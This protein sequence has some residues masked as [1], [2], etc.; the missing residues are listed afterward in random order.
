ML[1]PP[2]TKIGAASK[3]NERL[4]VAVVMVGSAL[5]LAALI[6]SASALGTSI[7]GVP[8]SY[9]NGVDSRFGAQVIRDFLA[10]QEAEATAL[11]TGDQTPLGGRFTDSAL[12]DLVQQISSQSSRPPMVRFQPSSLTVLRALDPAD[13][14][15]T[16]EVQEDGSKAVVTSAGPNAAPTEQAISFHGD[17]WLRSPSGARYAIAD[18]H[19]QTLPSSPLPTAAVIAAALAVVMGATWLAVRRRGVRATVERGTAVQSVAVPAAPAPI[20]MPQDGEVLPETLG[21]PPEMVVRT[22]GGLHVL[23]AG[24]DWAP[25]LMSRP[26]TGFVWL[27]LLLAAIAT[28]STQVG[29]DEVARQATPGL[30]RGVQ[31]KRLRN[32]VGKGL[33]EMPPVLSDRIL[34]DPEV[35]SF[36]LDGCGV[37]AIELLELGAE[38]APGALL[39]GAQ[40]A[41]VQRV[42]QA[43]QGTFLPEFEAI[44]DLATDRR[45]TCTGL[46]NELRE[47]LVNKRVDLSLLLADAHLQAGR[48]MLAIAV[49]E[50]A[51]HDRRQRKD[52]AARLAAA[53]RGAGRDA[54][55]KALDA[56]YGS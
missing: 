20:A 8:T 7:L 26:V 9:G 13:P 51:L 40:V 4:R 23:Q 45:P 10:D 48:P 47:L 52:L 11:S 49:L 28:P 5:L 43:C 34:V 42:V 14:T 31:L 46:V 6:V 16:I 41:R 35:M 3:V 25:A 50:S 38:L 33:R 19:I 39:P 54:E 32:V 22:F 36:R 15:L 27:R 1:S 55:A 17:F 56:R 37:D 2:L 12:S 53:Y 44:E 29:R 18:Q 24:T 21:P 30:S